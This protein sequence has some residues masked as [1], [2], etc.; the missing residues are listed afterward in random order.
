MRIAIAAECENY[1]DRKIEDNNGN[2]DWR[3]A[4]QWI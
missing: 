1:R 4:G 2:S 3:E